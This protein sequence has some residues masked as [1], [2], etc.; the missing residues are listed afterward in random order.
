M[1]KTQIIRN[2]YRRNRERVEILMLLD[3]P[4]AN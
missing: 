1:N 4:E 3:V 2:R